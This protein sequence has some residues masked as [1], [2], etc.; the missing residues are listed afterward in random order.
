MQ[1]DRDYIFYGLT[2]SI[3]PKCK[4]VI[5]AQILVK[6]KKV[7][8]KKRCKNH[9]PFI[10]LIS[11]D[12]DMYSK[13]LS[14]NKP[15][16]IPLE[17]ATSVK[18]GCP[19][20][21][22]LCPE[23]Q[24]HTC[25]GVIEVTDSCNL[26]CPVCY[27]NAHGNSFLTKKE[28]TKMINQYTRSEENP[29]VV[30]FTGGEPTLHPELFEFLKIANSKKIKMVMLN[31]NGIKLA[32]DEEFVKKLSKYKITVYLQFDG[33]KKETYEILRGK[34]IRDIKKKAIKNLFKYKIPI[35]LVQTT[36]KNV[37][38]DEIGAI[39]KYAIKKPLILG[40]VFQPAAFIGRF[41]KSDPLDRITLPDVIHAIEKQTNSMFVSE[42][43]IPLP[44]S[45][46]LCCSLTYAY[47][48]KN[49][50]IPITRK[51]KI[52]DYLDYFK[53]QILDSNKKPI[54]KSL[55]NIY[56]ASA[57]LGFKRVIKD[58][59]SVFGIPKINEIPKIKKNIF[60]IVIKPFMDEYTFDLQ[61][62][63]KCCVH[64]IRPDGKII[65]FCINNILHRKKGV[66]HG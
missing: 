34:D 46:P 45:Y 9:G 28:V 13:S 22:G 17:F 14:Y 36:L 31:T 61:R 35:V 12:F 40:I 16:T 21:C 49:K 57:S 32:E 54:R 37:N 58:L 15:G 8:M 59:Y 56:S 64:T 3:C 42:D 23:H 27:A 30:Q 47:R 29:Q 33:F 24:Q 52:E 41:T 5:D 38:D 55:E 48:N 63:M 51:I 4:K 60:K 18:K 50:I 39:V 43:F 44:C 2:R 19:H 65:P 20:D 62:A 10:G 53:N 11:S 26:N 1:K 25:V 6:D 7:Y 66:N